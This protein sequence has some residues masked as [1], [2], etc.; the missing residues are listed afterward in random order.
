MISVKNGSVVQPAGFPD[1]ATKFDQRTLVTKTG[2]IYHE[3]V[4]VSD[5]ERREKWC[6]GNVQAT[7]L[8]GVSQPQLSSVG[9]VGNADSSDYTQSDFSSFDW[10]SKKNYS[11]IATVEG[12]PCFVFHAAIANDPVPDTTGTANLGAPANNPNGPP[13]IPPTGQTAYVA[14][15][16]H[17]PV[18]LA[19]EG[20]IYFYQFQPAPSAPL[21]IPP[22]VQAMISQEQAVRQ[23]ALAAPSG[24]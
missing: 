12:V 16:S 20:T 22:A 13:Q 14:M 7:I 9:G 3:G 1:Q 11:A 17:L 21:T 6:I 4:A 10:V 15:D 2:T 19:S 8:P 18:L 24:P 5:G 23:Q